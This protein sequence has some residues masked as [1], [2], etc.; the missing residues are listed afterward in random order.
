MWREDIYVKAGQ[1]VKC[2]LKVG[3]FIMS[4]DNF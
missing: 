1:V 4:E 3:T 2:M